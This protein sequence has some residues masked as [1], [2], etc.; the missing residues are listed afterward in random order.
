M[1][2]PICIV[3]A[4]YATRSGYG[5][6]SRDIIRHL[7]ETNRYDMR[8]VSMPWGGCPLNALSAANPRDIPL[9]TQTAQIPIQLQRHPELFVQISVPN[10]FQPS[11]KFNIGITAGIETTACSKEWIDGCNRMDLILTISEH[12]KRILEGTIIQETDQ[13]GKVIAEHKIIK[14]IE[15]LHNCIDPNIFR[16]IQPSEIPDTVDAELSTIKEDFNF[17][18]VGH[19]LKGNVGEDRKNVGLLVQAFCETFK[20]KK[21]NR[22]A[23]IL[24]TS[25]ATFSFMDQKNTLDKIQAIRASVG[26]GCPNVYLLHGDLSEAEMNGLYNHP[27][28]KAHV[29]F[30]KGEGF[31]RPLLEATQSGKPVI[32]SGW[33]GH[34]DFLNPKDAVLLGGSLKKVE[35]G[36]VWP[37]VILEDSQWFNVD[38]NMAAMALTTVQK[39]YSKF[40]P[41]AVRLAKENAT[42]FSYDAIKQRTVDLLDKYVPKF[43]I[44]VPLKLP[45]LKKI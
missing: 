38:V 21:E 44:E 33:S 1:T 39:N 41:G 9:I 2:K 36:S 10:E 15:V 40:I 6:M 14:P 42:K 5:D 29:T 18:F 25:G 43:A 37:G 12:S 34:L 35:P 20:H 32:A 11:A 27:K 17:L 24:K 31:G 8:L 16:E 28:V 4:P 7:I 13:S 19:W 23:L 22:P 45:T 3:Q 26:E 30:T